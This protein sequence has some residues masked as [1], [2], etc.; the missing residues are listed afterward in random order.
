LS[1]LSIITHP[2]EH[3]Q[4]AGRPLGNN[5]YKG[6]RMM[7]AKIVFSIL[8]LIVVLLIGCAP[9]SEE[10]SSTE[11][12]TDPNNPATDSPETG[13][14]ELSSGETPQGLFE[15][16]VNDMISRSGGDRSAV[17][18]LKSEAVEWGDGSLGCPQPGMMYT[19][20]IV[21]GYHVILALGDETYDYRLTDRG[22]FLLCE[23]PTPLDLPG[24]TPT[25]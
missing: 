22:T 25:E 10:P 20:A 13:M 3:I 7:N 4:A 5:E 11:P 17:R 24:E 14:P 15:T 18:V 6:T 8:S 19:Q 16:V 9:I 21:S 12:G 1:D 2:L 23:N